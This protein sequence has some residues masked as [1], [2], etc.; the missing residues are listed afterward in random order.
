MTFCKVMGVPG[1]PDNMGGG[2]VARY[3]I[4][5]K[6]TEIADYCETDI[7]NTYRVWLLYELFRGK[8]APIQFPSVEF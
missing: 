2:E 6:I 4:E 5:G 3:L 8:V 7:V 1:K